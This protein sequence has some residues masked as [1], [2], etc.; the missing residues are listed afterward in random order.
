MRGGESKERKRKEKKYIKKGKHKRTLFQAYNAGKARHE[1][2]GNGRP[3]EG[4]MLRLRWIIRE[5][6]A[7]NDMHRHEFHDERDQLP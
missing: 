3:S 4:A 6:M 1:A 5:T 7:A 2:R